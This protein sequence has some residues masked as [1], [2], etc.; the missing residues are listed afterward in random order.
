M[1]SRPLIRPGSGADRWFDDP[2]DMI[3]DDGIDVVTVSVKVPEPVSRSVSLIGRSWAR[4]S[5]NSEMPPA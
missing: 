4:Y 3:R 5:Q 2:L 1:S